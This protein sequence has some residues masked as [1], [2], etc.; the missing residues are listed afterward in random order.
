MLKDLIKVFEKSYKEYRDKIILDRYELKPGLYIKIEK[1]EKLN[2]QNIVI[3][4]KRDKKIKN[5]YKTQEDEYI[6]K[7][8]ELYRWF[9]YRDYYSDIIN[10]GKCIDPKE[11]KIHSNNYLSFFIKRG[12]LSDKINIS[13]QMKRELNGVYSE[14]KKT[15]S[16]MENEKAI[17]QKYPEKYV[18]WEKEIKIILNCINKDK[19][20][21]VKKRTTKKENIEENSAGMIDDIFNNIAK[22]DIFKKVVK[23]HFYVIKNPK[24]YGRGEIKTQKLFDVI[25]KNYKDIIDT[26]NINNNMNI[27]FKITPD[28]IKIAKKYNLHDNDYIK[29]FYNAPLAEYKRCYKLYLTPRIFNKNDFNEII[30]NEIFGLSNSNMG[31]NSK[32]PFLELKSMK[33]KVPYQITIEDA[34]FLK[35]FFDW[36]NLQSQF[37]LPI[38]DDFRFNQELPNHVD[39]EMQPCHYLHLIKGK[40]AIKKGE[41]VIIDDYEFL[42]GFSQKIKFNLQNV[43][44][45]EEGEGKNRYI[46]NDRKINRLN[47][48]EKEIDNIFFNGK[49]KYNYYSDPKIETGRLSKNMVNLLIINKGT[50]HDYFWKGNSENIKSIIDKISIEIIKEQIRNIKYAKDKLEYYGKFKKAAKAYNLRIS[51]LNYFNL[52]GKEMTG[53]IKEM[54]G[55]MK[56]KISLDGYVDCDTD[57]E[58]YFISGQLAYYILSQSEKSNK[59]HDLIEPFL[60]A[61]DGECIKKELKYFYIRYKHAIPLNYRKYNNAFSMVLALDV[62][63]FGATFAEKGQNISITGAVQIGQGFNKY[64]DSRTEVQDVLSPFKN[65]KKEEADASSLGTKIMSDEAHYFY[66]FSVNPNNYNNYIDLIDGFNGYTIYAYQKFKEAALVSAT[67]FNTNSKFG[68]ENEFSMFVKCKDDKLY[69]PDLA[70]Y[71]SFKKHGKEDEKDIIDLN[72]LIF[73]NEEKVYDKIE[74]IEI[75]YN[76]YTTVIDSNFKNI[77]VEYKNIFTQEVIK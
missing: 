13:K 61:K 18:I 71:V 43:L 23:Q 45:I 4:K 25:L 69:L 54:I 9:K 2:N 7:N 34:L 10:T 3:I 35:I 46:A 62:M 72:K 28:I 33:C 17:K 65:P 14:L 6:N 58:F 52:G 68:C 38:P 70:Q 41:K 8:I 40:E 27:I 53:K 26:K 24:K 67:A 11:M 22:E 16:N 64:N 32:K 20:K 76:P 29:I 49:L 51:L 77:K 47:E 31:M 66:P 19:V 39:L 57:D 42:P 56:N 21:L 12:N 37:M 36:L 5:I 48:L 74:K 50:F 1:N 44:I 15:K 60:R 63:N 75:Y 55:K 30:H 73:L 59:N